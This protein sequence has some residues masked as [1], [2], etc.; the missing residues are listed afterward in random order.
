M[1]K[2]LE[3]RQLVKEFSK[4]SK[5]IRAVDDVS[6]DVCSGECLGLVGESG[7]GKS[8]IA[9]MITALESPDAGE[10][11]LDGKG[12]TGLKGREQR[13][14]YKDIQMV[15]QTPTDSFNPRL[16]LGDGIME[17]MINH[18]ISRPEA[19]KKMLE[20]LKICGLSQEYADRYPHQV[21]GGECQ[22][23][24]IARAIVVNPKL[25][26]CDEATSALDVTVQA[27]IVELMRQLKSENNMAYLMIC[28]D[29]ALVQQL[30]DRLLVMYQ[31]KIVETGTPDEI[32][33][34]PREDYTKRLIDSV[35]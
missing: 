29:L 21:S 11:F 7:S 12:I 33:M 5:T 32:I 8:T 27:Q 10:I 2:I 15:F 28:H 20:T 25:L 17:G 24:S 14:V 3:V 6:F 30:C 26:I 35:F 13:A 19:R 9:K 4:G 16:K 1:S 31:G 34:H 23:A 18:G 22:R